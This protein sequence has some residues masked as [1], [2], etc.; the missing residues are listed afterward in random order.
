MADKIIIGIS[1]K[2][3]SGKNTVCD[4]LQYLLFKFWNPK[5]IEI[6]SFADTLKQKVCKD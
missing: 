6:M 3:Q 2:K 1:G 4:A 5:D